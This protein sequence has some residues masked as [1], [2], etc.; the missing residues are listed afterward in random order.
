MAE[1][2]YVHCGDGGWAQDALYGEI[3]PMWELVYHDSFLAIRDSAF[4]VNTKM[5][6][7]DPLVRYLRIVLK[8]L[9]AGTLPPSFF[10]DDL[11]LNI[12]NTYCAE[13]K[14]NPA[15]WSRLNGMQTV[16]TV[17]RLS[18]WLADNVFNAPMVDHRFVEGNL[19]HERSEFKDRRG[20][21]VVYVNTALEPWSPLPG[22]TLAPLGFWIEGPTL[23]A[24]CALE[25]GGTPYAE[26]TLAAFHGDFR[27][28]RTIQ[29]YRAFG[30]RAVR[31]LQGAGCTTISIGETCKTSNM[32]LP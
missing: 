13:S 2:G 1:E 25:V 24:Y 29:V 32:K 4:H 14:S 16:V 3:V 6:T 15:G 10:S 7:D 21:T 23:L 28:G 17:S 30:D 5:D 22:I 11:T 26:P 20:R 8:T 27:P 18:T 31:V 9:R 19:F 12:I